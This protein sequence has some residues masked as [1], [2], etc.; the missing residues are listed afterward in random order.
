M[1]IRKTRGKLNNFQPKPHVT[2]PM[3]LLS[4]LSAV[5]ALTVAAYS[6]SD[7]AKNG[8]PDQ[9]LAESIKSG[10]V[11]LYKGSVIDPMQKMLDEMDGVA[12]TDKKDAK[13]GYVP[14]KLNIGSLGSNGGLNRGA[15]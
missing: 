10:T 3:N 7:Q 15:Y 5:G 8:K 6:F 1:Y 12:T 2:I 13:N 4:I 9:G 11:N 14:G